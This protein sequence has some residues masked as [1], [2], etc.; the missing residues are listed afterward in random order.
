MTF[1]AFLFVKSYNKFEYFEYP[2][3]YNQRGEIVA[4]YSPEVGVVYEVQGDGIVIQHPNNYWSILKGFDE[5]YVEKGNQV[6]K[7]TRLGRGEVV[8]FDIYIGADFVNKDYIVPSKIINV[9]MAEVS[10]DY[11][12]NLSNI[13]SIKESFGF[14][15][16]SFQNYM[17]LDLYEEKVYPLLS[18][19]VEIITDNSVQIRVDKDLVI[20]YELLE[21]IN[22]DIDQEINTETL[23]GKS[24]NLRVNVTIIYKKYYLD[25][26]SL[27]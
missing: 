23:I 25:F 17:I 27:E 12:L 10:T 7:T 13:R 16:L 3:E 22:V 21:S 24:S 4:L 6:N 20:K 2:F 5:I 15:F 19:K 18:G 8:S 26:R 11:I 1:A 14:P 9:P